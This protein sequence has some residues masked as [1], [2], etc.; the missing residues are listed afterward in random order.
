MKIRARFAYFFGTTVTKSGRSCT[1]AY[2]RG[3]RSGP[4]LFV[5]RCPMTSVPAL[6]DLSDLI[7]LSLLP[8]WTGR[9][10]AERLRSGAPPAMVLAE[11]LDRRSDGRAERA[12][13]DRRA[14]GA[15]RCAPPRSPARVGPQPAARPRAA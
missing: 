3:Q 1:A 2:N 6:L 15:G 10:A 7:A 4:R 8:P 13:F 11:I 12:A 9:D 14:R 5:S